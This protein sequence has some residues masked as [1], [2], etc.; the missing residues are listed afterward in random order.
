MC[1]YC[2]EEDMKQAKSKELEPVIT[3]NSLDI[4]IC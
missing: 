2:G 3:Y 1:K 4:D